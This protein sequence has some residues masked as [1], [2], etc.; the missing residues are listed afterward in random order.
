VVPPNGKRTTVERAIVVTNLSHAY[1]AHQAL[2]DVSLSVPEGLMFGLL[3]PNG[4]GKTTFF[5]ILTTLL[6]PSSGT[7][8][9]TGL[10]PLTQPHAVRQRLGVVLQDTALDDEL[11][12][13]ENL[14]FHGALYGLSSSVL[15]ERIDLLLEQF[16][17]S[18]RRD[19]YA[20][21]L[22]GGLQRRT[23]LCRGLLHRPQLL[24]LDE[25]TTGLDPAARHAFWQTLSAIQR[26]ETMTIVLATHLMDEA[27]RCAEVGILDRGSLVVQG[28]PDELK[29][30]LGTDV[31]LLEAED[32]TALQDRIEAQ[33]GLATQQV[34]TAVQITE[35]A[36]Q[37][38]LTSLYD[39]FGDR[40]QSATIRKPTLEDVFMAHAGYNLNGRVAASPTSSLPSS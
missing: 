34:G 17:L 8:R 40:I 33:F 32:P 14:R 12:V 28:A 31:L 22:S 13:E 11:T 5:R 6:R 35:G 4:S 39:A 21:T 16:G 30:A 23:D 29:Q 2:V 1:G 25:P 20:K 24:L 10:D 9:V 3:G 19:A 36:K 7:V 26:R 27:E 15:T 38:L 18:D 37:E